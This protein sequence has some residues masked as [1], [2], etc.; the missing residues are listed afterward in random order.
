MSRSVIVALLV[1]LPLAVLVAQDTEA[2][3][4]AKPDAIE[5][6]VSEGLAAHRAGHTAD[7]IDKLQK[8]VILLQ[9]ELGGGMAAFLPP[10]PEGWTAGEIRSSSG[11]MGSGEQAGQWVQLSRAYTRTAD[12]RSVRVTLTNSPQFVGTQ[13][14]AMAAFSNPQYVAMMNSNPDMSV[15]AIDR[16]GWTG[17]VV[18]SKGGDAQVAAFCGSTLLS[19]ESPKGDKGAVDAIF[20]GIDLKGLAKAASTAGET[21]TKPAEE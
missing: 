20:S 13:R 14:A 5:K 18:V 8:A 10:A 19:V 7:A 9:K 4:P 15:E 11:T 17:W 12:E 6:L 2:P 1:L 3:K 21:T 16:D